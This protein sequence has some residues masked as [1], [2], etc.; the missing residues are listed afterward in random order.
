MQ[1]KSRRGEGEE[2]LLSLTRVRPL[3]G[4]QVR[5]LGVLLLASGELAFV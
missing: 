5:A 4:L 1:T 3:M 2:G